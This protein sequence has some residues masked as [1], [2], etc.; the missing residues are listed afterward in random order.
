MI[1]REKIKMSLFGFMR[2]KTPE[3]IRQTHLDVIHGA[4]QGALQVTKEISGA[5]IETTQDETECV[6][7]CWFIATQVYYRAMAVNGRGLEADK[8]LTG[9]T[10]NMDKLSGIIDE[11]FDE[12]LPLFDFSLSGKGNMP[13]YRF[14]AEYFDN[15]SGFGNDPMS[16]TKMSTWLSIVIEPMIYKIANELK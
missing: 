4:F 6:V 16:I 11:R 5:D 2:K 13:F 1:N 14:S 3:E 9:I 10:V 15:I 7:F 12:Y 8:M